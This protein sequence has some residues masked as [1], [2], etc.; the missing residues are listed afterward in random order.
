MARTVAEV[1]ASARPTLNDEDGT[2]YPDDQLVGFVIDGL[3]TMKNGRPDLFLGAYGSSFGTM[4]TASALPIDEQFFRPIV[5]YVVFRAETKDD[6]H[7]VSGR[8]ELMA[9]LAI[10]FLS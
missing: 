8:A 6:E 4:T 2:R 5:D 1:I 10:G 3:N 7:V 9:K